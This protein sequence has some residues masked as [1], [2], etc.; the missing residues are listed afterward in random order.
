MNGFPGR[1]EYVKLGKGAF[2]IDMWEDGAPTGRYKFVGN[3]NSGTLGASVDTAQIYSSTE[4]SAG[5]LD[6]R[7]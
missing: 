6:K 7:T 5:L 2:F 3:V 4:S 1:G